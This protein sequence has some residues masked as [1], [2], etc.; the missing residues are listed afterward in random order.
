VGG[1]VRRRVVLRSSTSQVLCRPSQD[2]EGAN[3]IV[4]PSIF[5]CAIKQ[6]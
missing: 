1:L 5:S 4:V 2:G 6:S 3:D